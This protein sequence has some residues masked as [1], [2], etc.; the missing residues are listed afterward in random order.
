[1]SDYS[2]LTVDKLNSIVDDIFKNRIPNDSSKIIFTIGTGKGG[3]LDYYK[4]LYKTIGCNQEEIGAKIKLL[5]DSLEDGY[6]VIDKNGV[7]KQ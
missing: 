3:V 2:K 1:M 7:T 6:Y 5:E 4:V